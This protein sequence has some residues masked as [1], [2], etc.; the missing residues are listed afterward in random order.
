MKHFSFIALFILAA[1]YFAQANPLMAPPDTIKTAIKK[2][3]VKQYCV[4]TT[5]FQGNMVS[6]ENICPTSS[7]TFVNMVVLPATYCLSFGGLDFGVE[8]ACLK[9]CDDQ[10][11]CDTT[12]VEVLVV[13]DSV[14]TLHPIAVDD[15]VSVHE[16]ETVTIDI[17]D[18]DVLPNNG[19]YTSLKVLTSAEHGTINIDND[20]ILSYTPV[21]GFC[22]A[23]DTLVYEVCNIAGCDTASVVFDV[24]PCVSFDGIHVFNGFSPNDDGINDTWRIIGLEDFPDHHLIV[25]NRWGNS[26]LDTKDY[27]ND[28]NGKWE[29]NALPAGTYFYILNDGVDKKYTGSVQI[30]Y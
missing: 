27:Q 17:L 19:A 2:S 28:W 24:M 11:V 30:G 25:F 26:V 5:E 4:D 10:G 12:V 29:G 13:P 15:V 3:N 14:S 16:S 9:Y 8:T 1:S 21:A 6:I 7:G 20:A 23:M 22:G 18:N